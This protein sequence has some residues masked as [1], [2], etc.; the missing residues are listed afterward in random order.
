ML[1][2]YAAG[3]TYDKVTGKTD[4]YTSIS[5]S[6]NDEITGKLK[7]T[8]LSDL[9]LAVNYTL[10]FGYCEVNF[11]TSGA[12][13]EVGVFYECENHFEYCP[14]SNGRNGRNGPGVGSAAS[15]IAKLVK[16]V[17]LSQSKVNAEYAEFLRNAMVEANLTQQEYD[18]MSLF[19]RSN[20]VQ[21]ESHTI[22]IQI[23]DLIKSVAGQS[24]LSLSA[25]Q[26]A[27]GKQ[28]RQSDFE[29]LMKS[30]DHSEPEL[31]INRVE[32]MTMTTE[33]SEGRHIILF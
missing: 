2:L 14:S 32:R 15:S 24:P 11:G 10:N 5:S 31:R 30:C 33:K 1:C 22:T 17:N 18:V 4:I 28:L 25:I 19:T 29:Q 7:L 21:C 8:D 6:Y 20:Y 16:A 12:H 27:S 13:G 3:L 9:S 23:A 26:V